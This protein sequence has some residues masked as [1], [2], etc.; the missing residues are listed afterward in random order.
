MLTKTSTDTKLALH[1]ANT[2][3]VY[4]HD[5]VLAGA[6]YVTEKRSREIIRQQIKENNFEVVKIEKKKKNKKDDQYEAIVLSKKGKVEL[7]N[8]LDENEKYY[9]DRYKERED[10]TH[11]SS[12]DKLRT[13]LLTSRIETM[14]S[15]AG[16][17]RVFPL[18]KPSLYKLYATLMKIESN[19]KE[20]T[21]NN[22]LDNLP[23]QEYQTILKTDGIYYSIKE[24]RDFFEQ[25]DGM[26]KDDT[27]QSRAK[28]IYLRNDKLLVV[29]T[30]DV[31]AN[32]L[33][34]INTSAEKKL[35]NKLQIFARISEIARPLPDLSKKHKS[36]YGD[37][38]IISEKD[39]ITSQPYALV[40]SDGDALVYT[41]A[42]GNPRGITKTKDLMDVDL[43]RKK[44]AQSKGE[45]TSKGWLKGDGAIY[46]RVFVT[47]FTINGIG[48]LDYLCHTTVEEWAKVSQIN[49]SKSN[50]FE[51]NAYDP[52]YPAYE[53]NKKEGW[54][55]KSIFM[56][57]FEVN[58]LYNISKEKNTPV[59]L[60]YK[61]MLDAMAHSIKKEVRYYNADNMLPFGRDEVLIYDEHGYP[62]GK[63]KIE[64]ILKSESLKCSAK[65]I[66][67]L[68]A[69]HNYPV[70]KFF[71]E[72]ARNNINLK[73]IIDSLNVEYVEETLKK[74]K[75]RGSLTL[76][77]SEEFI[78]KIKKASKLHNTSI[79]SYIRSQ[80]YVNVIKDAEA[81]E[82]KLKDNKKA[83]KNASLK[84][85]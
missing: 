31:G 75:R 60:T 41:M 4:K 81:Y 69:L 70:I 61:D 48:S 21:T 49:F 3:I 46:P 83:W 6:K 30:S 14:F 10:A 22:Y 25:M 24:V 1:I 2:G 28:G 72:I 16:Q 59:I 43:S 68:P 19:E 47:P 78:N 85:N 29:Y 39:L 50:R 15:L 18:D 35:L 13:L 62:A 45:T 23:P 52:I 67:A 5:L 38:L 26:G 9:N 32:K 40:I 20:S 76:T 63:H 17:V 73:P 44:Y 36:Q 34:G 37:N 51:V 11:T 74:R 12:T 58:E 7:L 65:E 57:V 55:R 27:Y 80:I 71:N 84:S 54:N 8:A 42:T 82:Q 33:I 66:N 77:A 56:P 79:S 53:V 64:M